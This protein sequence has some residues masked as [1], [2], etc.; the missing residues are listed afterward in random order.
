MSLSLVEDTIQ[1][2]IIDGYPPEI[3]PHAAAIAVDA[4]EVCAE[5]LREHAGRCTGVY[6]QALL[7]AADLLQ[8]I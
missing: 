1:A 2:R 8:G 3:R 5:Q 4:V 7:D 6:R